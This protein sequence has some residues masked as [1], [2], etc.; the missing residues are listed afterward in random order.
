[1]RPGAKRA[2]TRPSC[3]GPVFA[4]QAA[5]NYPDPRIPPARCVAYRHS[6]RGGAGSERGG[7][8]SRVV[9]TRRRTGRLL[10]L[11]AIPAILVTV[12][13]AALPGRAARAETGLIQG[14]AT[15]AAEPPTE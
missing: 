2:S 10:A 12:G 3:A 6:M 14:F 8:E 13:G 11:V 5:R 7:V 1:M 15:Q 4:E 9:G